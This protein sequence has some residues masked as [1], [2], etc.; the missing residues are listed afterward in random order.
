MRPS[1]RRRLTRWFLWVACPLTFP[2]TIQLVSA[3]GRLCMLLH[4]KL[5]ATPSFYLIYGGRFRA[6][7]NYFP[8]T[9]RLFPSFFSNISHFSTISHLFLTYF[10]K[11]FPF[12]NY[13]W[14]ISQIFLTSQLL[15][16]YFST[17]SQ[18]FLSYFSTIYISLRVSLVV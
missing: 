4:L 13:F 2:P 14:P 7:L 11:N 6:F 9:S 15:L 5:V 18:L 8:V 12:L 16:S 17:I 1:T 3:K 10:S